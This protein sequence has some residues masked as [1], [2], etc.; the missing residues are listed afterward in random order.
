MVSEMNL[1]KGGPKLKFSVLNNSDET[2]AVQIRAAHR[3]VDEEGKEF[4]K[5]AKNE[6]LIFPS[7]LFL[8][9]NEKRSILVRY[10]GQPKIDK[11]LPFRIIAEQVDVDSKEKKKLKEGA[12]LRILLRYV[13]SLYVGKSDFKG[14]VD[15]TNYSFDKKNKVINLLAKN[16]GKK[17]IVLNE[18]KVRALKGKKE[19][20]VFSQDELK[21]F[22]N[23]VVQAGSARK[24]K[25]PLKQSIPTDGSVKFE[26]TY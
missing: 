18:L 24:F 11:E 15:F 16:S 9:A 1:D 6:F 25:M 12:N 14:K 2:I 21:G 22:F 7:Q 10:K 26:I 19:V 13:A 17:H 3:R 5:E 23:E 4:R 8:K 20:A